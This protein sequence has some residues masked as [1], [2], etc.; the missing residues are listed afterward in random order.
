MPP[1]R[2]RGARPMSPFDALSQ[3]GFVALW[4]ST[5]INHSGQFLRGTIQSWLV[6][7]L[8]NSSAWVGV[9]NGFPVLVSAPLSFLAGALA[10]R[11]DPRRILLWTRAA[12]SF[13]CF[14]T[15][16]AITAGFVNVYLLVVLATILN[17]SYYLSFPSNQIFIVALVGPERLLAA[18][19][20]INGVG[21]GLNFILPSAAG[22]MAAEFG[23]DSIYYALGIGYLVALVAV[24]FTPANTAVE[25]SPGGNLIRQVL[26]GIAYVK[27][28]PGLAWIFYIALLSITGSGFM[29]I[30]PAMARDEL[31][32]SAAGFG[33]IAGSQGV[34]SLVGSGILLARGEIKRKGVAMLTGALIWA[35]GMIAIGLSTELWQAVLAGVMMGFSPPLWMNSVQTVIMTAVPPNMRGRMASLFALTFQMVPLGYLVGGIVADRVGPANA[36]MILGT[37][38][39]LLHLPPLSSREFREIG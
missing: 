7:Q 13:F 31:G 21:F 19:A 12:T 8:T 5:G 11:S 24:Y 16:Y 32:L 28:R 10:D 14:V 27:T 26:A 35:T 18:N 17:A 9:V 34:G 25:R 4:L 30:L 29:A 3:R 39:I 23:I 20:L 22:Y 33:L 2:T 15:A 37:V 38:G 1:A 36:L 6:L